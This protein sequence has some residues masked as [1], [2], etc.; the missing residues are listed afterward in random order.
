MA[1]MINIYCDESCHLQNDRH[2]SMVLGAVWCPGDRSR[3][4]AEGLREIKRAHGLATRF[5]VKFTKVSPARIRFYRDLVDFFFDEQDLHF[6]ALVV[7]DKTRLRHVDFGQSHDDW[8]YK[9]YFELLKVIIDPLQH[10]RIYLDIKDTRSAAKVQ[11][12]HEVLSN[13]HYDFSRD[14][15]DFIQTVRSHE[16]EQMQLTDLLTGIVSYANRVPGGSPAKGALVETMRHRSRYSLT[17]TTLLR[18][19]KVNILSW[20]PGEALQ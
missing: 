17:R 15:I 8:Y 20:S 9:M 6:R 1:A 11:K 13:A 14:I 12:L 18:E 10:Y 19:N 7:P 4:I 5:E 16:V 2:R 3:A